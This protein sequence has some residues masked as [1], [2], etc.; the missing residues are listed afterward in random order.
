M[1]NLPIYK[2]ERQKCTFIFS[3]FTIRML[4]IIALLHTGTRKEKHYAGC[5][6]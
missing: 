3:F 2:K 6:E 4:V 5:Q 1:N